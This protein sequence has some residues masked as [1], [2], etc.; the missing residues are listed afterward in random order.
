MIQSPERKDSVTCHVV[1]RRG[2]WCVVGLIVSKKCRNSQR[3]WQLEGT[4]MMAA[5]FLQAFPGRVGVGSWGGG[6]DHMLVPLLLE[7]RDVTKS[8][9]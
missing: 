5:S 9:L 1:G 3:T 8:S 2:G 6:A 7:P 4:A